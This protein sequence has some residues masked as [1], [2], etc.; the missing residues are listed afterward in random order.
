MGEI[1]ITGKDSQN[2]IAKAFFDKEVK[3]SISYTW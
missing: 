2:M 1:I 3:Y